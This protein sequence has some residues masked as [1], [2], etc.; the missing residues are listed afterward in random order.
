MESKCA[1]CVGKPNRK[2]LKIISAFKEDQ[3]CVCKSCGAFWHHTSSGWDYLVDRD[4][5]YSTVSK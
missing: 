1:C 2:K 5:N 3:I 4:S